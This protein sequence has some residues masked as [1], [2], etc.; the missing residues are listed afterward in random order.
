MFQLYFKKSNK[1]FGLSIESNKEFDLNDLERVLSVKFVKLNELYKESKNKELILVGPI[2]N[3]RSSWSSNVLSFLHQSGYDFITKIEML[4]IFDIPDLE[5]DKMTQIFY[6]LLFSFPDVDEYIHRTYYSLD[7]KEISDFFTTIKEIDVDNIKTINK[8]Y[9]LGFDL[10]DIY[11]YQ[12]LFR[13]K[14]KRN[15]TNIEL[16]DLS[17]SNSEHSRHWFFN[18]RLCYNSGTCEIR[19]LFQHVKSTLNIKNNKNSLIAFSDNSSCIEGYPIT[20]LFVDNDNI[21]KTSHI[22]TN[23]TLTAETHNF[24]TG[25][26][27]FEG[28]STGIGGRIRDNLAVGRGG[29]I[30]A[31][32]AGYCV[33]NLKLPTLYLSWEK[34]NNLDLNPPSKI[35]IDA[36]NGASDYG[37]KIGEPIIYGFTRSF[38]L[39]TVDGYFEWLKPVMFTAGIGQVFQDNV[40]KKQIDKGDLVVMIGGPA[41]RIGLGGGSA[42][43]RHQNSKNESVDYSAVQRGD[44]E[45]ENKLYRVIRSCTE[46]FGENPIKSIHDQGAGGM[47][48]VAKEIIS[49]NG[50]VINLDNVHLGDSTLSPLEIWCSEY[51]EQVMIVIDPINKELIESIGKR[52]NVPISFIGEIDNS[53]KITVFYKDKIV[54]DLPL[55]EILENVPKKGFKLVHRSIK[56]DIIEYN[57]NLN[58]DLSETLYNV[59]NLV[60]VGSKEFLVHKVDR[61]VTGLIAQQQCVGKLQLPLSDYSLVAQSYFL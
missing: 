4:Y 45:M 10:E 29:S 50:G 53:K 40:K 41:Y 19:S 58:D 13:N 31:S 20:N 32:S 33:G 8:Q 56:T 2:P 46:L 1:I 54:V 37:N 18:G 14:L 12:N 43:S 27:P 34:T 42:S 22:L 11:F 52:E 49:P 3:F 30:I 39:E 35:L 38:G 60:S 36:S 57:L 61:S 15:P 44:P 48:N 21:Y 47:G 28:A 9:S 25:I 17:Q 7:V 16:F 24:P 59:F 26:C 5:I 51:Q 23:P 6:D 55:S